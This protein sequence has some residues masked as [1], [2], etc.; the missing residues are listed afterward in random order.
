M[1]SRAAT[2]GMTDTIRALVPLIEHEVLLLDSE[3]MPTTRPKTI[4]EDEI[5]RPMP[6]LPASPKV[7]KISSESYR[8]QVLIPS[9]GRLFIICVIILFFYAL[10]KRYHPRHRQ[11][12]PTATNPIAQV[13]WRAV[14]LR[15]LENGLIDNNNQNDT[16]PTNAIHSIVSSPESFLKHANPT[17][18]R[19]FGQQYHYHHNRRDLNNSADNNKGWFSM[20]HQLMGAE[21]TYT[22]ERL[23]ALRYELLTAFKMLNTMDQRILENEY[24]NWLLDERLRCEHTDDNNDGQNKDTCNQIVK[25]IKLT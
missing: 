23:G 18:Y 21:L 7:D 1:V 6:P 22:R 19:L 17:L 15:D 12:L 14:F 11:P 25:E 9:A 24:W 16:T 20:Q 13:T 8:K 5:Q 10:F 2:K 4:T 3:N